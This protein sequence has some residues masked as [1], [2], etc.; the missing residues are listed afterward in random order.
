MLGAPYLASSRFA[1]G[2]SEAGLFL[3]QDE[4]AFR[5]VYAL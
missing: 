4:G 5:R 1:R 3:F 2:V